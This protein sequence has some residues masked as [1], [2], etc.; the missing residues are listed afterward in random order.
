MKVIHCI[1]YARIIIGEQSDKET[2]TASLSAQRGSALARSLQAGV[3]GSQNTLSLSHSVSLCLPCSRWL[4]LLSDRKI[5]TTATPKY[6]QARV[7][8]TVCHLE[9]QLLHVCSRS[10]LVTEHSD[11]AS[12]LSCQCLTYPVQSDPSSTLPQRKAD[13]NK[14]QI[15]ILYIRERGLTYSPLHN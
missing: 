12:F 5:N 11:T 1:R 7:H 8:I 15:L 13:Q 10:H 4:T 9:V 6:L 14:L 3:L 2:K